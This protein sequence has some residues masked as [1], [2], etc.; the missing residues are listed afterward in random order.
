VHPATS[1]AAVEAAALDHR[2][3]K[4]ALP[5]SLFR[6]ITHGVP[7]EEARSAEVVARSVS[8]VAEAVA[9]ENLRR[10]WKMACENRDLLRARRIL[11]TLADTAEDDEVERLQAE[12]DELTERTEASLRREF[13]ECA[14]RR[15]FEGLLQIGERIRELLPDRPVAEDFARIE[16]MLVPLVGIADEAANGRNGETSPVNDFHVAQTAS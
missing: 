9:V 10:E 15:D 1:A 13:G 8:A 12:L 7:G 11:L 3:D 6:P 16:P 14:K 4:E 2:H 5:T